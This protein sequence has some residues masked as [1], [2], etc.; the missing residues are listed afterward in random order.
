M[1]SKRKLEWLAV[2]YARTAFTALLLAIAPKVAQ[3]VPVLIA[4]VSVGSP[5][6]AGC[7]VSDTGASA[8]GACNDGLGISSAS[9]FAQP[10][11]IGSMGSG[12]TSDPFNSLQAIGNGTASYFDT[13]IFTSSDPLLTSVMVSMNLNVSG[14][15]TTTPS[16]AASAVLT[17]SVQ[18]LTGDLH[19]SAS[20]GSTSVCSVNFGASSCTLPTTLTTLPIQVALGIPIP[21][22]FQLDVS[23]SGQNGGLGSVDFASSVAFPIGSDVFNLP[24]GVTAN[25]P[26]SFLFDNR[27]NPTAAVPG[28]IVG[29]GLP[30]L[31]LASG[32]LLGW[33]RR[34]Q[35]TA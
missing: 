28:P 26:N 24:L 17:A 30:G 34:R 35:K 29:A 12:S 5:S 1:H 25:A 21:V 16:G 8:Q 2:K 20:N 10:G 18:S 7:S 14:I 9:A 6:G 32:G 11:H 33:W 31:I 13:V 27:Y 4:D 22:G 19:I 3:A 15:L 23:S